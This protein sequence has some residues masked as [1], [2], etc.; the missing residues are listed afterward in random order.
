MR[1]NFLIILVCWSLVASSSFQTDSELGNQIVK[2]N[3]CPS[4]P[5]SN[6]HKDDA[7]PNWNFRVMEIITIQTTKQKNAKDYAKRSEN[8]LKWKIWTQLH[9]NEKSSVMLLPSTANKIRR[10]SV[11]KWCSYWYQASKRN[12]TKRTSKL[13]ITRKIITRPITYAIW[14]V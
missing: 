8:G 14:Q 4:S 10:D 1:S 2:L 5:L 13:Q 11:E 3:K 12:E 9:Q 7:Q 6:P